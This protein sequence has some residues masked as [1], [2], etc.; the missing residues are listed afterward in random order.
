MDAEQLAKCAEALALRKAFPQEL[1]GLY[2]R[3]EM[4]QA[5]NED[6]R[7][8]LESGSLGETVADA[9]ATLAAVQAGTL[10]PEGY[11]AKRGV[12]LKTRKELMAEQ[13]KQPLIA[14][15]ALTQEALDRGTRL[16]AAEKIRYA[17]VP[18]ATGETGEALPEDPAPSPELDPW[19]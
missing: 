16:K 13:F 4:A 7:A 14:A 18:G 9:A 15:Q 5:G 11:L 2:T 12:K 19:R 3:D 8:R 17:G 10:S 1:S 6:A